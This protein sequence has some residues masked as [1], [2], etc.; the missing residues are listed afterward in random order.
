MQPMTFV[1][2][3]T[4]TLFALG[5]TQAQAQGQSP[6]PSPASP[7]AIAVSGCLRQT[8]DDPKVFALVG[9]KP[10]SSG[11]QSASSPAMRAPLYRL[12]DPGTLNLKQHAGKR[13]EIMGAVTPAR[14]EKGADIVMGRAENIGIDTLTVTTIDLKP[15]PRLDVT[16][17]KA[18]GEC[19]AAKP[20]P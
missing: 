5:A 10:A 15:A 7:H 8:S 12:E 13:V 4:A 6:Q 11:Q 1:L 16:S 17:V 18:V 20:Q 2:A 3:G 19:P 14:D 9:A